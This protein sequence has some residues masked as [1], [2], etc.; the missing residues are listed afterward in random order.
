MI[1]EKISKF[2]LDLI[3][4]YEGLHRVTEDGRVRSYRDPAGIWTIGWGHTE[5]VAGNQYITKQEAEDFLLDDIERFE[6]AVRQYVKVPLTQNQFDALVSFVFNLGETNFRRSTL[7]RKL[8]AGQYDDIPHELNRWNKATVNGRKV[9]LKGLTRRRAAE[10]ALFTMD[11]TVSAN[12]GEKPVRHV[13]TAPS[14]SLSQS[15][16]LWGVSAAGLAAIV[17]TVI[18]QAEPFAVIHPAIQVG[19]TIAQIA[20]LGLAAYARVDDHNKGFQ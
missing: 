5:G 8:N 13:E 20:G 14:K 11:T 7:L 18:V 10:G 9:T 16:T 15:R 12:G 4:N 2:G 6:L 1:P 3:K 19:L 17:Q